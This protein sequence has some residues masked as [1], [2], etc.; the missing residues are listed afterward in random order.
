M[1]TVGIICILIMLIIIAFGIDIIR[2][3][4]KKLAEQLKNK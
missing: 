2:Q 3:D 1:E 4:I